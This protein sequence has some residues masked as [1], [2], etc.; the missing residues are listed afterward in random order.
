MRFA[1]SPVAPNSTRASASGCSV[2]IW[3]VSMCAFIVSTPFVRGGHRS[4]R[5]WPT[6]PCRRRRPAPRREAFEECGRQDRHRH[7]FVD[8]GIDRPPSLTGIADDTGVGAQLRVGVQRHGREIEQ[9]RADH[10]ASPPHL[11]DLRQ[12]DVVP[13]VLGSVERSRLGVDLVDFR[14]DVGLGQH[15]QAFRVGGHQAVLDAVV[16][17]LDEVAG[18]A[19]AAVQPAAFLGRRRTLAA[20]RPFGGVDAGGERVEDRSQPGD[21]L[22]VATDHQAVPALEAVDAAARADVEVVDPGR[23]ERRRAIDVVV[24]PR[25]PT[26]DQHVARRQQ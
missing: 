9:P 5:A 7:P 26:V 16:H 10:R 24:V 22:G 14:T 18:A 6:G 3:V 20:R 4:R 21:R 11:G 25:V 8:G 1:R 12:I 2:S 15:V 13:V 19:R 23:S 17:H